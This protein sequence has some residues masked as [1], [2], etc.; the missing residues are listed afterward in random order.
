MGKFQVFEQL[1]YPE[2]RRTF[3][4]LRRLKRSTTFNAYE[5][6]VRKEITGLRWNWWACPT[7]ICPLGYT[8]EYMAVRAA[9]CS[10][11][12]GLKD[13]IT[14]R[15]LLLYLLRNK[16]TS[17]LEMVKIPLFLAVHFLRHRTAR[18][19]MFSQRYAQV[20]E[21]EN[22]YN[23]LEYE[24]GVRLASKTNKQ[25]STV[26]EASDAVKVQRIKRKMAK[27]ERYSRK[28]RKLYHSMVN[29][30]DCSWLSQ[31]LRVY[32]LVL[33]HRPEQLVK[34]L[35]LRADFEHAQHETA[36]IATAIRDLVQPLF[37]TCIAWLEDQN[38]GVTL[39][40]SEIPVV[41]DPGLLEQQKGSLRVELVRKRKRLF[42]DLQGPESVL[43]TDA[44]R[45]R[46]Q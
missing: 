7:D 29:E 13:P 10:Y 22:T 35:T 36:V 6:L 30:D 26:A 3:Y 33:R 45:S 18:V 1:S 12:L 20:P 21:E 38:A 34:F 15:Q 42:G 11:G 2:R 23:P 9:R 46:A 17:P 39:A 14:D 41:Q 44:K 27:A 28:I 4:Q 24:H 32:Y 19:N 31:Q 40:A 16:H 43:P 5:T 25:G 8:P 37:P